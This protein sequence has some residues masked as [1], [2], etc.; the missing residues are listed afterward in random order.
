MQKA[1]GE[2]RP[3]GMGEEGKGKM[4]WGGSLAI[5]I[6]CFACSL[7]LYLSLRPRS[8]L[9][10]RHRSII[11]HP[12][13]LLIFPPPSPPPPKTTPQAS[14]VAAPRCQLPSS[15]AGAGPGMLASPGLPDASHTDGVLLAPGPTDPLPDSRLRNDTQALNE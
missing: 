1:G 11:T 6:A 14:P 8:I 15:T 4:E 5:G 9:Q 7:A 13:P 12:S 3:G 10:L 2:K